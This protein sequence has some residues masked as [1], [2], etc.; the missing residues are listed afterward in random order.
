MLGQLIG[1]VAGLGLG[2]A[3]ASA[4]SDADKKAYELI[5]QTIND[6]SAIGIPPEEA[7]KLSLEKYKSAGI[8]SPELE[9]SLTQ[10]RTELEGISTDPRLRDT[11]L[12]SLDELRNIY[13]SGGETL[14]DK[15]SYEGAMDQSNQAER[16]ARE[17]ILF[18][19]AQRGGSTGGGS[20]AAQLL[21]QQGGA[22]RGHDASL[23][24][25]A[26][27]QQRAL[28]AIRTSG[29]MA[30][31]LQ[32]RDFNQQA[33]IK[34]A[35]D[36]INAANINA[37]RDVQQRNIAAKNAAQ[38]TNLQ[39]QQ[40]MMNQNVDISNKEQQYNKQLPQQ[41]F[42]NQMTLTGAKANARGQQAQQT[43]NAGANKASTLAGIGGGVAG[44][45][46]SYDEYLRKART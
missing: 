38:A 9:S 28:D 23:Q 1:G 24:R 10:G 33:Q 14:M 26:S 5:Q 45:G 43:L 27:A 12:A 17:A 2:L 46:T 41:T 21:N 35:Q 40:N 37:S 39:N 22:E 32:S 36:A 4:M 8:L 29:E 15:A 3:G 11:E 30:G 31:N 19:A 42:E 44:L 18:D 34:S 7:M 6:Y 16:G 25:A 20:L 13:E